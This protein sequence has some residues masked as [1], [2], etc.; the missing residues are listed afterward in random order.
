MA[1]E[2]GSSSRKADA[3]REAIGL[4]DSPDGPRRGECGSEQAEAADE[5]DLRPGEGGDHT[6]ELAGPGP[7]PRRWSLTSVVA[8]G[9][10]PAIALLLACGAGYLKW[11]H[12]SALASRLA[13][14][15]S[16]QAAS[17]SAVAL[18]SYKPDSVDRDLGAASDRLTGSFKG[19]YT[20]LIH[21][22]V[23]PGAKQ[24]QISAVANVPAA[25][26]VS[27]SGNQAVVMLFV[28]QTIIMGN[29]APTATASTVRVTLEKV[30]GRWLISK[31]EPI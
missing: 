8:F 4:G 7:R 27:V 16:V 29:D 30:G 11:R 18:L 22:I 26:S 5:E 10:L 24:K 21:D 17:A 25:A 15:E 20:S 9:L 2:L 19:S 13:Q 28:D 23:I 3:L 12:S 31:F 14:N 6:D 1:V